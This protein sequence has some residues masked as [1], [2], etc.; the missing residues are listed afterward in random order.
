MAGKQSCITVM[1]DGGILAESDL[2]AGIMPELSEGAV[3]RVQ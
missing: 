1:L 3:V 2:P